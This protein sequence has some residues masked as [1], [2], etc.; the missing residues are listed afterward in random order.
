MERIIGIDFGTSTTYM[1][2]KRYNGQQ[3]DGSPS[4]YLPVVFENGAGNGVVVSIVRENADGTFDFGEKAAEVLEGARIYREIKMRLE[5]AD[6]EERAQARRTTE[7]FFKFLYATYNQQRATLGDIND[8]EETIVSYPVKWQPET[9]EFMCKAAENAGFKNVRGMDEASA[10]VFAMLNQNA[11]GKLI[12]ANASGYLM[13]VDMGAGTTDLVVCKYT[14]DAGGKIDVEMVTSWP[15]S[16]DEPTFGGREIDAVLENYVE[17][18]LTQALKPEM[19][20]G[21]HTLATT[22]G[23]AKNW[24]EKNVSDSLCANK[25]VN[26]CGYLSNYK[27]MGFIVGEFPAFGRE[28]FEELTKSGLEDYAKL[29]KGCLDNAAENDDGF[30]SKGLDFVILTGGHSAWY[31]ARDI[32]DGTMDGYLDHTALK[33]IREEKGRVVRLPNPQS[34][35]SLGLVYSRLPFTPAPIP[36]PIPEPTPIPVKPDG[37]TYYKWDA[38]MSSLLERYMREHAGTVALHLRNSDSSDLRRRLNVPVTDKVFLAHDDSMMKSGG[39]GFVVTDRG[40]YFKD[41]LCEPSPWLSWEEFMNG[42]ILSG[43]S[44]MRLKFKS[45]TDRAFTLFILTNS[46]EKL[47]KEYIQTKIADFFQGLQ[48]F[49]RQV[50]DAR[51]ERREVPTPTPA[52]TPTPTPTPVPAP[53]PMPTPTPTI[54]GVPRMEYDITKCPSCGEPIPPKK[55]RCPRCKHKR[56]PM[57]PFSIGLVSWYKGEIKIGIALST[58][59]FTVKEDAIEFRKVFGNITTNSAPIEVFR[60]EN[61]I[62]LRESK[63]FLGLPSIVVTMN[64]GSV[65]TFV[66][67][68]ASVA[69]KDRF[70]CAMALLCS[71]WHKMH[72]NG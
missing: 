29:L 42:E 60:M 48:D 27:A 10:A 17:A 4:T 16:A 5:S 57:P 11:G 21:A 69:S 7:E 61:M 70:R 49:L 34:T 26:T 65:Y 53:T 62:A 38:R 9:V 8:E 33:Q 54:G 31:F 13:L 2:V 64:D 72:D 15:Q 43:G 50:S 3:P 56:L 18:Y 66:A 46:D 30:A 67:P 59:N 6:E 19:K 32:L 47:T 37:E 45:G 51:Q 44:S 24:K 36:E 28:K 52:P 22:A 35:V 39:S 55:S 40:I 41:S 58:G 1:Y 25:T 63:Y 23:A 14:A 71:L 68:D 12:S 20:S